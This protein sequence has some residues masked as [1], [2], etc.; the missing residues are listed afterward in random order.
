[1]AFL[2]NRFFP[3]L[4]DNSIFKYSIKV[5]H[6]EFTTGYFNNKNLDEALQLVFQPMSLHYKKDGNKIFVE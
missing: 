5:R 3:N 4:K 6:Q 1:M 2:W